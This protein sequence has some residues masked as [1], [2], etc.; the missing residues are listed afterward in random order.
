MR[1]PLLL[2]PNLDCSGL[3]VDDAAYFGESFHVMLLVA[4]AL[5]FADGFPIGT[6]SLTG[7]GLSV[8]VVITMKIVDTTPGETGLF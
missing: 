8:Y 1:A 4:S 7:R 5:R 3:T 6:H 2:L